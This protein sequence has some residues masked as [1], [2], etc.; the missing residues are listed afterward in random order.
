MSILKYTTAIVLGAIAGC[1]EPRGTERAAPPPTPAIEA[2]LE[3]SDS[4]ARAGTEIR[5]L[6][7]LAGKSASG[8]A[9]FTGKL[10]FDTTALGFVAE[11]TLSDGATRA[12]SSASGVLRLAAVAP[13]GFTNG[14]LYTLRFSVRRTP[15]PQSLRL[16]VDE[17]HTT[18]GTD[19]AASLVP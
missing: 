11:D 16:T 13:A 18:S 10:A 9:S 7:R 5:V 6:V 15:S 3:L 4:T 12:M 2:R 14:Q 19:A 1:T 8:I 17:L